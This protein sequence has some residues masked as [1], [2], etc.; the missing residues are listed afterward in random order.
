[1]H[2]FGFHAYNPN[3][4]NREYVTVGTSTGKVITGWG[5][6]GQ[7]ASQVRVLTGNCHDAREVIEQVID[8]YHSKRSGGYVARAFG[9]SEIDFTDDDK[10]IVS[11]LANG[12]GQFIES[13]TLNTAAATFLNVATV[14]G[15]TT[16]PETDTVQPVAERTTGMR[17]ADGETFTRP[18]GEVYRPRLIGDHTDVMLLRS[19]R[20]MPRPV[21]PLL[22]GPA[23]SGKTAVAEVAHGDD[24]ITVSGH[25]QMTVA[26][27]VGQLMPTATGG[28]EFVEGPLTRAMREGKVL[29][30]DEVNK[31]PEEVLPV[32]HSAGDGRGFV[33]LDDRPSDPIVRAAEGF[34]MIG[35]LN[36][37]AMG[38]TGLSEAI[39]SRFSVQVQVSTDF[40]AARAM[41]CNP[42]LVTVAENLTSQNAADQTQMVGVWVPQMRELLSAK[43]L[44]DAGLGE[45]FAAAA[46]LAQCP[47]PEDVAVVAEQMARTLGYRVEPL[48]MGEQA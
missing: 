10:A 5:R 46:M 20:T 6:A 40:D 36:P 30:I 17:P 16:V 24:L 31:I 7:P 26:H 44:E 22:I 45:K 18:N 13:Q 27:L 15:D 14:D 9:A 42:K 48:A 29:L 2:I 1:M 43:A 32:L 47:V 28:W 35:T 38:N 3:K 19:F 11:A 21:H 41:G 34:A 4:N 25:G 12:E 33:R 23:G 39:T 8:Q 37:D